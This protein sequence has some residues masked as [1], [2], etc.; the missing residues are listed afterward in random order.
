M[1]KIVDKV[2]RKTALTHAAIAVFAER[3]YHRAT[4]QAVAERAGV[5]KGGVYEYFDSKEQLLFA[6]AET[7]L[8]AV[9]EQS[10][11]T[12]E[13][14]NGTVHDRLEGFARATL[15]TVE[16]WSELCVLLLQVWAELGPDEEGP[17]RTLVGQLYTRSGDRVQAVL[18]AAIENG[19]AA[20]HSSRAAALAIMAALDGMV[21]QAILVPEQFR[22]ALATGTFYAWCRSLVPMTTTEERQ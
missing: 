17:L 11:D 18:D 16:D 2:E 8:S 19:E 15:A 13:R 12:L 21:L 9:F 1:P 4:M 7:L 22:S 5:S 6:A 10:M 20:P 3:G 14:S